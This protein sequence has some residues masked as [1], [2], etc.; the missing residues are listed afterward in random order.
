MTIGSAHNYWSRGTFNGR[1]VETSKMRK[2]SDEIEELETNLQL[3][4]KDKKYPLRGYTSPEDARILRGKIS[5]LSSVYS[6]LAM[7]YNSGYYKWLGV[8]KESIQH[9]AESSINIQKVI[10]EIKQNGRMF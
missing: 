1:I 5:K 9:Q 7:E 2:L 3:L 10:T 6:E 4:L 8:S